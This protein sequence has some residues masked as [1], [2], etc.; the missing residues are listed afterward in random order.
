MIFGENV[1]MAHLLY[2]F[3]NINDLLLHK[4]CIYIESYH[5]IYIYQYMSTCDYIWKPL[6]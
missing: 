1:L 5:M 2:T 6:M 3:N 4:R